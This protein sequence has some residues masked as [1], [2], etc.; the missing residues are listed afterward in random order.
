MGGRLEA[1]GKVAC[2]PNACPYRHVA[3]VLFLVVG[4]LYGRAA[5]RKM[6]T[7]VCTPVL[8]FTDDA[9]SG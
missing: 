7:F 9:P 3:P 8:L 2:A 4:L 5:A 6:P 1:S